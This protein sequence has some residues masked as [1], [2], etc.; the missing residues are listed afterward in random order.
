MKNWLDRLNKFEPARL[1]AFWAALIL[2]LATV[3]VTVS[4]DVDG[5]VTAVIGM[6]AVILPWIQGE[7]TRNAVYSPA[8]VEKI[9]HELTTVENVLPTHETENVIGEDDDDVPADE[10]YDGDPAVENDYG[11]AGPEHVPP[12]DDVFNQNV[13]SEDN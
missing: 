3:G 5:K 12:P 9:T 1:R 7:S 2:L 13:E 8:T 10:Y 6:I 4:A 11:D